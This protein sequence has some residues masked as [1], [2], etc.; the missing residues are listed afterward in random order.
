VNAAV[1]LRQLPKYYEHTGLFSG[2]PSRRACCQLGNI[3]LH[4][5]IS[6]SLANKLIRIWKEIGFRWDNW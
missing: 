4:R 5:D 6:D 1:D 2:D 3:I